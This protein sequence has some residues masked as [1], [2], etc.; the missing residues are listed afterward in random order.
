M[1]RRR[2]NDWMVGDDW[3]DAVYRLREDVTAL[4]QTQDQFVTKDEVR[5]EI[6]LSMQTIPT[7]QD[8]AAAVV[9]ALQG[10]SQLP[11][12]ERAKIRLEGWKLVVGLIVALVSSSGLTAAIALLAHK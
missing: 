4:E 9:T 1:N 11:P 3:K 12:S 2:V 6:A 8:I 7:T 5:E 10:N